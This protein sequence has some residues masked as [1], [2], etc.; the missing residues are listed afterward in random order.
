MKKNK[1]SKFKRY[2]Y[3]VSGIKK[4]VP[5]NIKQIKF[6][7]LVVLEDYLNGYIDEYFLEA[8]SGDL[9]YNLS[10]SPNYINKIDSDLGLALDIASDIT[11]RQGQ[12]TKNLKAELKKY[13]EKTKS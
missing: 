13:F 3:L 8:I 7:F 9:Y 2:D 12:E 6:I 1:H 4:S 10:Q 11:Y 5:L